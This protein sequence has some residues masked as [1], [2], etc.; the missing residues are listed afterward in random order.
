MSILKT[1]GNGGIEKPSPEDS[2]YYRLYTHA[3]EYGIGS[4]A[5]LDQPG[6]TY[7]TNP[8]TGKTYFE[9]G[10]NF[11]EKRVPDDPWNTSRFIYDPMIM[12]RNQGVHSGHES[13]MPEDSTL[14]QRR[15]AAKRDLMTYYSSTSFPENTSRDSRRMTRQKMSEVNRMIN[16][17]VTRFGNRY[18]VRS[19]QDPT[20]IFDDSLGMWVNDKQIKHPDTEEM[21]DNPYY[22]KP[23]RPGQARRGYTDFQVKWRGVPRSEARKQSWEE[24]RKAKSR[25]SEYDET[26]KAMKSGIIGTYE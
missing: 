17:P 26:M 9:P 2:E 21:V 5:K 13:F 14:G 11:T 10:R 18:T 6:S 8:T 19:W 4:S 1:Y 22:V 24:F 3:K 12:N 15:R 25:K 20:G 7:K 16:S 23:L